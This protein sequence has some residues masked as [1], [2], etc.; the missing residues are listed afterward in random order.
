MATKS[1]QVASK[2]HEVASKDPAW[3]KEDPDLMS[4]KDLVYLLVSFLP[5]L[6]S[7]PVPSEL[8]L[9]STQPFLLFCSSSLYSS[10]A[11]FKF[12]LSNPRKRA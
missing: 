10:I 12:E 11:I 7:L 8:C 4:L 9:L 5:S 3:G 2:D 1:S 6:P